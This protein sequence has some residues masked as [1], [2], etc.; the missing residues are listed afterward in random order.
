MEEADESLVQEG[1]LPAAT[2]RC[3]TGAQRGRGLG[4]TLGGGKLDWALKAEVPIAG[5]GT[6]QTEAAHPAGRGVQEVR[7]W[8]VGRATVGR[9]REGLERPSEVRMKRA[10]NSRWRHQPRI[11][12]M[13]GSY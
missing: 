3:H 6:V 1:S 10:L 7:E 2:M 13:T 11:P 5:G 4:S 12:W 9:D 8:A